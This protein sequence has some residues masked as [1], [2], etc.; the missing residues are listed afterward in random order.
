MKISNAFLI[1]TIAAGCRMQTSGGTT[2]AGGGTEPDP[3]TQGQ[4]GGG[5][6][7]VDP[8]SCP[9]AANHC[10]DADVIFTGDS[11]FE[12]GYESVH[13][14]R[15]SGQPDAQGEADFLQLGD[16]KSVR[17]KYFWKTHRAAPAEIQVGALVIALDRAENNVYRA[18][19]TRQEA[20]ESA[21]F[22]A[23]IVNVDSVAQ[24]YVLVSGGYRV[25]TDGL[26]AV[27]GD[28]S[29]RVQVSGAEDAHFWHPDYYFL[30]SQPLPTQGYE[31]GHLAVAIKEPSPQTNG[32]GQFINL[33]TGK[34]VWSKHA[35]KT[36]PAADADLKIG[37]YMFMMD[38]AQDSLYH[39]PQSREQAITSTWFVAKLV[40]TK[41]MYKGAVQVA[42]GY[43]VA[44]PGLRVAK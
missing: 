34:I 43:R 17:T 16:G 13:A 10:L 26:R 28:T 37:A 9:D 29:P 20:L 18:P 31:S 11:A 4:S 14:S 5:G 39:A 30:A 3:A 2:T 6:G 24:G 36:R 23:R 38:R 1:L 7:A 27:D 44:R 32:D 8:A 33:Q 42:G 15:Q 19:R 25:S 21:W 12:Q 40:D 22:L 35:W 41:E